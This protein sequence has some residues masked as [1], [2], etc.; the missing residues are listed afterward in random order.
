MI[1][2]STVDGWNVLVA[3]VGYAEINGRGLTVGGEGA[4]GL[5][6]ILGD[7]VGVCFV[8]YLSIINSN[9]NTKLLVSI[10]LITIDS[11]CRW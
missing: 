7:T 8:L 9:A 4:T 6:S 5:I 2:G 3:I 11:L 10:I 1:V